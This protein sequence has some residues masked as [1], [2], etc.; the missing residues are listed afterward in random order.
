MKFKGKVITMFLAMSTA[1]SYQKLWSWANF[2]W[3]KNRSP[4]WS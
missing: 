3:K 1:F 4:G 2:Q